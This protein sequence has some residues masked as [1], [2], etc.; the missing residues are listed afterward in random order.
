[1][2]DLLALSRRFIDEG[3]EQSTGGFGSANRINFELSEVADGLAV[4]ES[5][6][7]VVAFDSG[8]GLVLFDTSLD[9]FG[10]AMVKAVRGW[11]TDAVNTLVYTHGHIDHVGGASAFLADAQERGRQRPAVIGHDHVARRF[12]RYDLT[13]GYNAVIN[14]RQFG[15]SAKRGSASDGGDDS[16]ASFPRDWVRPTVTYR[17]ELTHRVGDLEL[18]FHHALGETDDHTW[19]WIPSHRAVCVG[20][21]LVW[22]FPNAGNP[23]KVQRY[24]LEWAQA[25]RQIALLEPELLLPAH[26]LP[27][28]GRQR[29]QVV[30][31]DVATALELLVGQVLEMMNAGSTLDDIIH[32][33]TLPGDLLAKPY[34]QATYDEPEFV[35]RNI[36]RAYGGWYDGNPA[37]LKPPSDRSIA[38]ETASLAG[39]IEVLVARANDLA[40]AE[41]FRLACHLI[42]LAA[43]A[44]P[45][46]IGA[47]RA[48]ASIYQQRRQVETSLMAKGIYGWAS[49]ESDVAVNAK[50][51]D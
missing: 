44:D 48:R 29:I 24:P 43:Q 49:R 1:M 36:W 26:G 46:D 25:L 8:D 21:L 32:S 50:R 11:R 45:D 10:P 22:V 16:P 40:Q 15:T 2:A 30:I 18:A 3:M 38:V 42:E 7:H 27:I 4:V 51:T 41:D 13:N 9:V 12:D 37:R 6:S 31:N 20:D 14:E 35:V 28:D 34:L 5:F 23:Q 39:G 33:V 47:Q 17:D 19:T